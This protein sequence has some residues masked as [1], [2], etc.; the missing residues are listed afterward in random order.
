MASE[1]DA[2][3]QSVE[4]YPQNVGTCRARFECFP[5]L[6][7]RA[8]QYLQANPDLQLRSCE[9]ILVSHRELRGHCVHE[10]QVVAGTRKERIASRRSFGCIRGLRLWLQNKPVMRS[11]L[12]DK[13]VVFPFLSDE[14]VFLDVHIR[15]PSGPKQ[16][17]LDQLVAAVNHALSDS[18]LTG[19]I[20]S[21]ESLLVP[22]EGRFTD[23]H[24]SHWVEGD[25]MRFTEYVRVFIVRGKQHLEL[26]AI[27]DF[28]P[29]V[30]RKESRKR[31]GLYENFS[32]VFARVQN[33][34]AALPIGCRVVSIRDI[35]RSVNNRHRLPA[36]S[37]ATWPSQFRSFLEGLR[38]V[39]C[40]KNPEETLIKR[41]HTVVPLQCQTFAPM[42]LKSEQLEADET[43]R[44]RMG[45]W[46]RDEGK[47]RVLAVTG[48]R[49][50][51]LMGVDFLGGLESMYQ[52]GI[53]RGGDQGEGKVVVVP[54][55]RVFFQ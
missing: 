46:L 11:H 18:L 2:G 25:S 3:L 34:L 48:M 13:S 39:V 42:V 35:C 33:C 44:L 50:R 52:M 51:V 6:L 22:Y 9:S 27:Q 26:L 40:L 7:Q 41:A 29:A 32:E 19:Q 8:N 4:F 17:H 53:R 36:S 16:R 38:L 55:Y 10:A 21:V 23:S 47:G 49:K 14:V 5:L 45:D 31:S 54:T 15:P 12:T 43:V 28:W 20:L 30:V 1:I 24:R 37:A